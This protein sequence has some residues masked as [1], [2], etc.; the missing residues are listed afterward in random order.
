MSSISNLGDVEVHACKWVVG[1]GEL[2][3][4]LGLNDCIDI[5]IH[6]FWFSYSLQVGKDWHLMVIILAFV[7]I[8]V[9]TLTVVTSLPMERF[10]SMLIKDKE[11]P[12]TVNVCDRSTIIP[13]VCMMLLHMYMINLCGVLATL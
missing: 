7:L 11:T 3:L 12:S 2:Y 9:I 5:I 1:L 13:I 8:D 6:T 4:G 10:N